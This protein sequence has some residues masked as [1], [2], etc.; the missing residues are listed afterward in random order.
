MSGSGR[1]V[2]QKSK[3]ERDQK[4]RESRFFDVSTA[5]KPRSADTMVRGRFCVKGCGP[6]HHRLRDAS[7]VLENFARHPKKTFSTLSGAKRAF[8]KRRCHPRVGREQTSRCCPGR[9]MLHAVEC[10]RVER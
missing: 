9:R 2:L 4:F 6:S 3:I 1:I 7:A 5:A 10:K 8:A